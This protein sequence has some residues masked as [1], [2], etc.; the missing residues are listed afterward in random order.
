MSKTD[1]V[2]K[3]ARAVCIFGAVFDGLTL[4]PMLFPSIGGL[5]FGIQ[6]FAPGPD[7]RY[8]MNL[9][10]SLM[11]GWTLLLVWAA[12]R[13]I[14]REAVLP[15]T[16]IVVLG[17]AAAGVGAV[18]SGLI[19]LKN[20]MPTFVLQAAVILLFSIAYAKLRRL[21]VRPQR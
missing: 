6:N 5:I 4:L 10:A 12:R 21:E 13:P 15:L 8:A 14:L 20:M 11:L 2:L 16:V 9:S 7:Y 18:T 1:S 3:F 19:P 17:L